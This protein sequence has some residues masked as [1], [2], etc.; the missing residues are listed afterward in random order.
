MAVLITQQPPEIAFSG[1]PILFKF[2]SD[3]VVAAVGRPF[4]GHLVFAAVPGSGV[5]V[6]L[7]YNGTDYLVSFADA[8]DDSGE[9]FTK[10]TGMTMLAFLNQLLLELKDNYYFERDFI[11]EVYTSGTPAIRFTAREKDPIFNVVATSISAINVTQIQDGVSD[12]SNAN[13]K[14]LAELWVQKFN[15]GSFSKAASKFLELDENGNSFYDFSDALNTEL[16]RDGY[17]KPNIALPE[18][19]LADKTTCKYFIKYAEVYG[20]PQKT[21]R[22]QNTA[23]FYATLGGFS[24]AMLP[25]T[26]IANYF[27]DGAK[28]NFLKQTA[29]T[30]L[31]KPHADAKDFL[32]WLNIL[33]VAALDVSV[34]VTF[35]DDST[36]TYVAHSYA[37]LVKYSKLIIPCGMLDLEVHLQDLL[38]I[39]VQYSVVLKS[40]GAEVSETKT[41]LIDHQ[42]QQYAQFYLDLNSF[43]AYD[44]RF[45]YGKKSREYEIL[46]ETAERAKIGNFVFEDGDKVFYST[47]SQH[48]EQVTTGYKTKRE[49]KGWEDFFLSRD[50]YCVKNGLAYP[51][52]LASKSVKEWTEG[53]TLFALEFELAYAYI[54]QYFTIDEYPDEAFSMAT[55]HSWV[56]P[57]SNPDPVN[58]DDRY[59][60]KAQTYNTAQVDALIAGIQNQF[61]VLDANTTAQIAS[62]AASL[63]GKADTAHEHVNYVTQIQLFSELASVFVFRGV[64]EEDVDELELFPSGTVI[65]HHGKIYAKL[66]E[67]FTEPGTPAGAAD[68]KRLCAPIK[69]ATAGDFTILDWQTETPAGYTET[70][71]Q[72]LGND[73]FMAKGLMDNGD[74]T[75]SPYDP[76]FTYTVAGGLITTASFSPIFNGIIFLTS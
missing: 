40:A 5:S 1:N 75:F 54:D 62:L 36:V 23:V 68:W 38:K 63:A 51:V 24:K 17:D 52:S 13:F 11:M 73:G 30:E 55:I 56:P 76:P 64:W 59:Y 46:Q 43:G 44:G 45:T 57:V 14:V 28:V 8:A 6:T 65:H 32:Y 2:Q 9:I 41:F 42:P 16:C 70:Y 15:Q 49:I 7:K 66:T 3:N 21:K 10:G 39:P 67:L 4:I 47:F 33:N 19:G 53:D 72:L 61:G 69:F 29:A 48:K 71:A 34:T 60:L 12:T 74:G 27:V 18:F 22:T 25:A 35:S 37:G 20:S 58:F 26:T 31:V 50:K